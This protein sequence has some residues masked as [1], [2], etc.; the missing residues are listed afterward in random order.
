MKLLFKLKLGILFAALS[1]TGLYGQQEPQF[2]QNMYNNMAINPGYA[3]LNNGIC[4]T[5]IVRQQWAGFKDAEGNKVGPQTYLVTIN[6]PVRIL[7][8][9]LSGMVM[10]DQLGFER[11]INV[12]IGYAYHA[13]IGFGTLGAGFMVGFHNRFIDFGKLNPAQPDPLLDQLTG[14]ESEMLIDGSIG[15]FYN[16]PEQYYI[17]ISATQLMETKGKEL[18][19]GT[20]TDTAGVARTGVLY[21]KLDRTF[22]LTGGYEFT[23]PSNPAFSINPSILVKTNLSVVQY[24]IAALV[25]YNNKFWGGLNY[26]VQDAVGIL[27]GLSIKNFRFG[28]SYDITTSKLGLSR[29]GGSHEIMLNYC[30]KIQAEKGRKSYKNTR[31]L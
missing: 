28:Y 19:S 6:S 9:G 1:L 20:Y 13:N 12:K 2:T 27:V 31:F 26:R 25:K 8:G 18:S 15:I 7:R 24:D 22:Y 14:E 11:N 29:T 30:F 23:I 17:G 5:G 4:I 21:M 16:V 10:Q 3:G